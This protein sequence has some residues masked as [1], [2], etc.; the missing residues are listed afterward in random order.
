MALSWIQAVKL[1]HQQHG[2]K[3]KVPRKGTLEYEAV[4]KLMADHKTGSEVHSAPKSTPQKQQNIVNEILEELDMSK[5]NEITKQIIQRHLDEARREINDTFVGEGVK[6]LVGLVPKVVSS[7]P[8]VSKKTIEKG[9]ELVKDAK[10]GVV[11]AKEKAKELYDSWVNVKNAVGVIVKEVKKS[12]K[13]ISGKGLRQLGKGLEL[14]DVMKYIP[15][16][17]KILGL[18]KQHPKLSGLVASV[19]LKSKNPLELIQHITSIGK[20]V[21]KASNIAKTELNKVM[22]GKGLTQLGRGKHQKGGFLPFLIPFIPAITAA[23][24]SA[25]AAA[26]TAAA[27]VA[28]ARVATG[29]VNAIEGKAF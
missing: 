1:Y 9:V 28:G 6:E 4:R 7:I 10:E 20:A 15:A 5:A 13:T 16:M 19:N 22:K 26:G 12:K 24:S 27:G 25:A 29:V 2:T 11:D 23:L 18:V 3:Y 17:D 21:D 14:T 8:Q